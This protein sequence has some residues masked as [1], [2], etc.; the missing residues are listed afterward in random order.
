ML[1]E[2]R[3]SSDKISFF[4]SLSNDQQKE[5]YQSISEIEQDDLLFILPLQYLKDFILS[6]PIEKRDQFYQKLNDNQ[7]KAIYQS[8]SSFDKKDM[9]KVMEER[10]QNLK[11]QVDNSSSLVNDHMQEIHSLQEDIQTS[12][13]RRVNAQ[14]D[15]VVKRRE[16][17]DAKVVVKKLEAIRKKR[18]QKLLRISRPSILDRVGIFSRY[19]TNK[20]LEYQNLVNEVNQD[21]VDAN[22][23][24]DDV[25]SDID[26]DKKTI[27]QETENL[28]AYAQQIKD[29]KKEIYQRTKEIKKA[30]VQMRKLSQTEKKLFGRKLYRQVVSERD[31]VMKRKGNV[32]GEYRLEEKGMNKDELIVDRS[33]TSSSYQPKES[34]AQQAKEALTSPK[35]EKSQTVEVVDTAKTTQ[36]FL[37][38][39]MNAKNMGIQFYPAFSFPPLNQVQSGQL[40]QNPIANITK[41]QIVLATYSLMAV[42]QYMNMLEQSQKQNQEQSQEDRHGFSRGN[43]HFVL[44]ISILVI[45]FFLVIILLKL[46]Q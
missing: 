27:I 45:L 17:K 39:V 44:L 4:S 41:A 9:Q 20:M 31:L 36:Q 18:Y 35:P 37:N 43:V 14:S 38:E 33:L 11:N 16:L 32:L 2:Y 42:Y 25:Q 8:F 6:Y 3:N 7:L 23:Y 13:M 12:T 30:Q 29:E 26:T 19:K 34:D 22:L 5:L 15:L 10:L 46:F 24:K 28:K 40:L 1:N 21:L